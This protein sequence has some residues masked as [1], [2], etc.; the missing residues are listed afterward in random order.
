MTLYE[1]MKKSSQ[2]ELAEMITC[3]YSCQ[4]CENEH[5][6]INSVC[7]YYRE[8]VDDAERKLN[9]QYEKLDIRK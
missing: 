3:I 8:C 5:K 9:W 6:M 7:E 2:H 1:V 4:K